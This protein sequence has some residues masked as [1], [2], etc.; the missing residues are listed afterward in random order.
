VAEKKIVQAGIASSLKDPDSIQMRWTPFRASQKPDDVVNYCGTY[1][2]KNSYGGYIGFKPFVASVV[3]KQS[4]IESVVL[5]NAG[6]YS[7][8][9][10]DTAVMSVCTKDGLDPFSPGASEP[11]ARKK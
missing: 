9:I 11:A 7:Q 4:K 8:D 6:N 2:A 10:I 3:T 1:N 5:Q